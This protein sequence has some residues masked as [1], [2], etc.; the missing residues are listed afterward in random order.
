MMM[1]LMILQAGGPQLVV[2]VD[3]HTD[4]RTDSGLAWSIGAAW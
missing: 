4:G 2:S 3:R 1:T